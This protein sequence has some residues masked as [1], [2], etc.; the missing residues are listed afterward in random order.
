MWSRI[1]ICR[2]KWENKSNCSF[3]I[4]YWWIGK[5]TKN[6]L[7]AERDFSKLDHL[8]K[9]GKSRN[10]QF[11]TKARRTGMNLIDSDNFKVEKIVK[12]ITPMLK[13]RET[14]WDDQQKMRLK[15]RL[16]KKELKM[17]EKLEST[18][19]RYWLTVSHGVDLVHLLTNCNWFEDK[20]LIKVWSWCNRIIGYFIVW[21]GK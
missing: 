21:Q 9:V 5:F 4:T 6:H 7:T 1:R 3:R 15:R 18:L 11:K 16:T 2:W 12:K 13:D 20:I 8:L 17:V 19:I 14:N 10:H